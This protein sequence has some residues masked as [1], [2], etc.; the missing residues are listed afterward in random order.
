MIFSSLNLALA[1]LLRYPN[2]YLFPIKA[3]AK[4]PPLIKNN[5]NDASNDPKQ[6][7][8]WVEKFTNK[9]TGMGPNWGLALKKSGLF[10]AD[11]DTNPKK[12]KQ[13]QATYD[14][15]D[16]LYGWPDT[17]TVRT[18]S[19]GFHKYYVGEHRFALG[20]YGLGP[21]IDSPNYVLIAG[22]TFDDGTSYVT[23]N[24]NI[25]TQPKPDWFEV[26][27]TAAKKVRVENATE[28]AIELDKDSQIAWAKDYLLNDAEPSIEGKGGENTTFRVACSVKDAGVSY[29]TAVELM[30][31]FYNV[32]Y[33]CEPLWERDDLA[34]KI[35]NA[36]DYG[37]LSQVGGK[38]A[39]AE[40]GGDD[41][42]EVANSI[43][44]EIMGNPMKKAAEEKAAADTAEIEETR[45]VET[46]ALPEA[47][48]RYWSKPEVCKSF[49]WCVG[50]ERFIKVADPR[51]MWKKAAF[52]SAFA[53][54][55]PKKKTFCDSLLSA[56][57]GTIRRFHEVCYLPGKGQFL[58]NGFQ[59]N[60][61]T[62]SPLKPA[63]GDTSWWEAH[64][65][66]L[67]PDP[68]ERGHVL[69]WCA[70]M[71][72]NMALKPK[73]ALLIQGHI[74]GTGKSFIAEVMTRILG[75]QNVSAVSQG[76]L[77]GQFNGWAL[78]SK[79]LVI[80]ELRAVDRNEV[81][82]KLHDLI[83]Q[84][85]ISINEKNLPQQ[86]VM[87]CFGILAMTNDDAAISLDKTDRRYLVVRTDAIPREEAYY[88]ALYARLDNDA[89]MQAIFSSLMLRDLK[90][91]DARGKAPVTAAK[92]EMIDAGLS[93]LEQ[94]MIDGSGSYPLNGRVIQISD[95][96]EVLP[97]RLT[98]VGRMHAQIASIL[99]KRFKGLEAGQHR[100]GR[101]RPRLYVI[102]GCGIMKIEG[103]RDN[104]ANIYTIDKS[105][106]AKGKPGD[107]SA[108]SDF[109]IGGNDEAS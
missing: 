21:D 89:A 34:K 54:L 101:D 64:L 40:F 36:Y 91:Y 94:F 84:E 62:P 35:R 23:E 4:F 18:P 16:L 99:K 1:Y 71:V 50:I 88:D 63:P 13:G 11:I 60:C 93:D 58:G 100:V 15:L 59:F 32:E 3:G 26:V 97:P 9:K 31:E 19:G 85:L 10:V 98:R 43:P 66:Y 69:D 103:W 56:T 79:L 68:V 14:E 95:V 102:N 105:E 12:G 72:Q 106:A 96:V 6:I 48:E 104:I 46:A 55:A 44:E 57:K 87:N 52:E 7:A 30:M 67:F 27:I 39:E 20:K 77:H 109:D 25:E 108:E 37:S 41:V 92:R 80:E 29:E 5:L 90:G 22:C 76:D 81:K 70:W 24:D 47:K 83:T 38:S 49:V 82:N 78:R 8:A 65:E 51:V 33:V 45:A 53:Y 17:E 86:N 107:N 2:R 61:Y 28:A 74:Q 42:A 73:H 75:R